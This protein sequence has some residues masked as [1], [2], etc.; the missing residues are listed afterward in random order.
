MKNWIYLLAVVL[1]VSC[2]GEKTDS[3]FTPEKAKWYFSQIESECNRDG[4]NLWGKNLYGPLMFVE[5]P[6][7]HI[8]ANVQDNEG[9]LKLKD[10]IY[11]GFYPR[12][13]LIDNTGIMFGGTLY[14]MAPLPPQED[15]LRIMTRAVHGLFHRFQQLSGI[16]P[17]KYNT[18]LMDEKNSRL[19]LKLE[20][21]AL[22]NAI[23][24][25]GEKRQ[26]SV[27]DALVFRGARR[28]HYPQEVKDE[29]KFE[30]YEGLAAFTYAV[31]CTDSADEAGRYLT[32][33]LDRF[34]RF[35]SYSRSYG[36]IHGALYAF[37]L[38]EKGFNFRSITSDTIDLADLTRE[39]YGIKLPDICRDVA[40]SLALTYEIDA[41]QK[42]EEQR[43]ADMK[44]RIHRQISVFTEKPVL[45]LELESPY[46]DFEPEEIR[47][48]DTLGTIYNSIRVSD[49]WGKLTVEKGGCLVSYNL[50]SMRITAKNL[51]ESKN[52]IYGEGWHIILN[53]EWKVVKMEDN[54]AIRKLMP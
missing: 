21:R 44:E 18:R 5:R 1:L 42:E 28:E 3:Y 20:W 31:I 29:N 15:T 14:A 43:L 54:Y 35:Q 7:R 39:K 16:E 19:L 49:N 30:T 11:S 33:V 38:Y 2:S 37:L 12:E 27:R 46:F 40:G 47:S 41:V 25:D 34:Y 53:S 6:G 26:Q 36:F 4:G 8:T 13:R 51:K 10:G 48:L 32:E 17:S 45:F 24:S 22:R 9:L 23:G 50:R 52:H